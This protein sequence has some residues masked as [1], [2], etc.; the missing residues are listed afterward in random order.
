MYDVPF[1]SPFSSCRLAGNIN[2]G[3]PRFPRE[4]G[5]CADAAAPGRHPLARKGFFPNSI[6]NNGMSKL[7]NWPLRKLSPWPLGL[8]WV[9]RFVPEPASAAGPTPR[10][11]YSTRGRRRGHAWRKMFVRGSDRRMKRTRGPPATE[12][13]R[14]DG[15]PFQGCKCLCDRPPK[16]VQSRWHPDRAE[17]RS[18][19]VD[20]QSCSGQPRAYPMLQGD[21]S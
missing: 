13:L 6:Q 12:G 4:H 3:W 7:S 20:G 5:P 1:S 10:W 17:S 2:V 11:D 15:L 18:P 21:R 16:V 8:S 9:Q 14:S 19:E